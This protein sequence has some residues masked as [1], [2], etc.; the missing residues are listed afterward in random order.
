M[1]ESQSNNGF[2]G[3]SAGRIWLVSFLVWLGLTYSPGMPWR[4]FAVEAM[5]GLLITLII[6]LLSRSFIRVE[7]PSRKYTL[8]G[9]GHLIAYF[10]VLAIEIIKANMNMARIVLSPS[11]PVRP[12]I[13]RI[14]TSLRSS[15]G[16]LLLSNSI[17]LTPGTI[18]LNVDGNNMFIHWVEVKKGSPEERGEVIKGSFERHLKEVFG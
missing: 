10:C 11:L 1:P 14:K 16:K 17:T 3:A 6:S 8:G 4:D 9:I 15:M 12:G 18:T 7:H 13:V 5:V 2:K